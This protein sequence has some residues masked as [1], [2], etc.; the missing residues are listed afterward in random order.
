[1]NDSVQLDLA[2]V[3]ADPV[4]TV[5]YALKERAQIQPGDAVAVFGTGGLG[6]AALNVASALGASKLYA[7]DVRDESLEAASAQTS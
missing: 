4:S 1:M 6:L 7:V 2:C 5:Y 3:A